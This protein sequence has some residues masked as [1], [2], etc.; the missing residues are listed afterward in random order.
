MTSDK[1]KKI[2][3]LIHSGLFDSI[4]HSRKGLIDHIY[5]YFG[6][7]RMGF[8]ENK[9]PPINDEE[10]LGERLY[11]EKDVLGAILSIKLSDIYQK[12][13]YRTLL[14]I[15]DSRYELDHLLSVTDGNRDYMIEISRPQKIEKNYFIAVKG[16]FKKKRVFPIDIIILGRKVLKHE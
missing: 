5:E 1:Q 15:D 11:S 2:N 6:F 8:D 9:L 16:D 14:V 10:D 13:N 7:A 3:P 4:C 12:N